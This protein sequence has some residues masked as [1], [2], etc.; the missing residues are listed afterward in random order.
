VFASSTPVR[1]WQSLSSV[2]QLHVSGNDLLAGWQSSLLKQ[3]KPPRT[4]LTSTT[5]KTVYA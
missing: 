1:F 3:A 2:D 5:N 4:P